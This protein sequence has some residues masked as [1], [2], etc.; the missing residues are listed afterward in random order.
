[1]VVL[2]LMSELTPRPSSMPN[3]WYHL[4]YVKRFRIS[5]ALKKGEN[6]SLNSGGG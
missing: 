1:M 5:F 3:L 6:L 2:D 4:V